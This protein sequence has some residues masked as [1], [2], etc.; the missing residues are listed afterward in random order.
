VTAW[1]APA[2]PDD[3]VRPFT[4]TAQ[5]P[6]VGS[7]PSG[8]GARARQQPFTRSRRRPAPLWLR[9]AVW[10]TAVLVAAGLAVIGF[11][12]AYPAW[13]GAVPAGAAAPGAGSSSGA[14]EHSASRSRSGP[15]AGRPTRA[16]GSPGPV[17]L[18]PSGPA[19]AVV[20]VESARYSVEI[21]AG[22]RCWVEVS[23]PGSATPLFASVMAAGATQ[24]FEAEGG[25]LVVQLGASKVTVAVLLPGRSTPA[26]QWTPPAAPYELDFASTT[27]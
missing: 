17:H 14:P 20:S 2:G 19:A 6:L 23:A 21:G 22:A 25:R 4:A 27:S 5:V 7:D 10:A 12:Q 11:H 3:P 9:L 26:W 15:H 16:P 18:A 13:F 24:S 1:G 8:A